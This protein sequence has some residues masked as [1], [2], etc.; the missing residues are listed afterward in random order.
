VSVGTIGRIP[1]DPM[2]AMPCARGLDYVRTTNRLRQP[3]FQLPLGAS[4]QSHGPNRRASGLTYA[5]RP[6][7]AACPWFDSVRVRGSIP[8]SGGGR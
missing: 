3:I 7:T 8:M 6:A 4:G 1:N 2:P 5:P